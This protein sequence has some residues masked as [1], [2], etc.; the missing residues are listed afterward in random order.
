MR[1]GVADELFFHF[2]SSQQFVSNLLP[3]S[4]YINGLE[5]IVDPLQQIQP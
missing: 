4:L 5:L 1:G 3:Y 2:F